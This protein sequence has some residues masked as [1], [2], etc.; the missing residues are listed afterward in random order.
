MNELIAGIQRLPMVLWSREASHEEEHSEHKAQHNG[1]RAVVLLH[2]YPQ[3]HERVRR[4]LRHSRIEDDKHENW[5]G[6]DRE[7]QHERYDAALRTKACR[8]DQINACYEDREVLDLNWEKHHPDSERFSR[9]QKAYR[10]NPP[11]R[12]R[13]GIR[14]IEKTPA[15]QDNE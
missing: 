2:P 13:V 10:L 6:E 14:C 8:S 9:R 12:R 7:H 1:D 4:S 3:G 15:A 11:G 5:D